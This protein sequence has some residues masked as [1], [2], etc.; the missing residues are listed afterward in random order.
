[1]K[2]LNKQVKPTMKTVTLFA[3]GNHIVPLNNSR[4]AKVFYLFIYFFQKLKLNVF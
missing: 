3:S 4:F 1:M 2:Q